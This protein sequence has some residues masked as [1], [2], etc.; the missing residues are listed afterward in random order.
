MSHTPG[1]WKAT[2]TKALGLSEVV[3]P[4]TDFEHGYLVC[5]INREWF[6][7]GTVKQQLDRSTVDNNARL[8]AAA[9]KLLEACED[10]LHHLL[11]INDPG[12]D[13]EALLRQ[14]IYKATH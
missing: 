14:A 1:P 2:G 6:K 9:P 5:M 12:R 3:A 13:A 8:I 10:A 7:D 4:D 11:A